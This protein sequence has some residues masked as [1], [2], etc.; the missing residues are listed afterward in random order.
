MLFPWHPEN[1]AVCTSAN[2]EQEIHANEQHK[3]KSFARM[4]S[5][6]CTIAVYDGTNEKRNRNFTY[7][8]YAN[9]RTHTVTHSAVSCMQCT[10]MSMSRAWTNKETARAIHIICTLT[11]VHRMFLVVPVPTVEFLF[12]SEWIFAWTFAPNDSWSFY[13]TFSWNYSPIYEYYDYY[14]IFFYLC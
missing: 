5:I 10:W 2:L 8:S 11:A 12:L 4:G 6:V 1:N 7:T 14:I 13:S 3:K 9:R